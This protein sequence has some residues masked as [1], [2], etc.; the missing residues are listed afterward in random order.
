MCSWERHS[1]ACSRPQCNM[2][3]RTELRRYKSC[4]AY[5]VSGRDISRR[6][7]WYRE[8]WLKDRQCSSGQGNVS[9]EKRSKSSNELCRFCSE[10]LQRSLS[11]TRSTGG[12]EPLG[13]SSDLGS[14]TNPIDVDAEEE[15]IVP[16]CTAGSQP[17]YVGHHKAANLYMTASH[18]YSDRTFPGFPN[19]TNGSLVGLETSPAVS[20]ESKLEMPPRRP[21]ADIVLSRNIG[22]MSF[23]SPAGFSTSGVTSQFDQGY[24]QA[25]HATDLSNQGMPSFSIM[26]PIMQPIGGPY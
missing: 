3:V 12:S 26:A 23:M 4:V 20:R 13:V 25:S 17:R 11:G 6:P 5:E 14:A 15:S 19:L 18:A 8:I 21:N 10:G 16:G 2:V 1:I 7:N 22:D 24:Y 9:V